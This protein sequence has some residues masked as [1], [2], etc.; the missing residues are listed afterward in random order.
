M[1]TLVSRC[2]PVYVYP[3][4][5]RSPDTLLVL[6]VRLPVVLYANV[7]VRLAPTVVAWLATC[8]RASQS[9]WREVARG[10]HGAAP[11]PIA[12]RVGRPLPAS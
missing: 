11:A 3:V 9:T 1:L 7:S 12:M 10:H 8:S 5:F 4:T 2:A 6:P